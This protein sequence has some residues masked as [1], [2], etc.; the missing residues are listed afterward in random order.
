MR[1]NSYIRLVYSVIYNCRLDSYIMWAVVV[2]IVWYLDY[3]YLC[4]ACLL[5]LKLSV[6]ISLMVRCTRYNNL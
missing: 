2:A 6:R 4:N 1:L 3:N 5:P